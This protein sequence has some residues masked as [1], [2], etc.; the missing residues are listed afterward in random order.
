[1]SDRESGFLAAKLTE[2]PDLLG[3]CTGAVASWGRAVGQ[4]VVS[5]LWQLMETSVTRKSLSAP[6]PIEVPVG[7]L[8][9]ALPK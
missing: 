9:L 5:A 7:M 4:T 3:Q 1:M 8:G 6:S 2:T